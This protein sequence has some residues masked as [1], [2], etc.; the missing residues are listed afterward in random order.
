MDLIG[1][2]AIVKNAKNMAFQS[3]KLRVFSRHQNTSI[4][5]DALHSHTEPRYQAI[6]QLMDGS[7]IFAVF[8]IRVVGLGLAIR[9]ISVRGMHQ[10]EIRHYEQRT[11]ETSRS[12]K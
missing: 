3:R 5:E 7:Y 2:Q 4:F 11:Q 9:P 12:K 1:M 6:G 10:R 8:T